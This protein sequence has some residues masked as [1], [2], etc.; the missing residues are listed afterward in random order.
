MQWA[1]S[2][3]LGT[4]HRTGCALECECAGKNR[5]CGT[6][7]AFA[8]GLLS[9]AFTRH[10]GWMVPALFLVDHEIK[11]IVTDCEKFNTKSVCCQVCLWKKIFWSQVVQILE[12][13]KHP[14]P[15][16]ETGSAWFLHGVCLHGWGTPPL[17]PAVFARV[18]LELTEA[19]RGHRIPGTGVRGGCKLL[20]RF[21]IDWVRNPVSSLQ[22]LCL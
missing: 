16:L 4:L 10:G 7:A 21:S 6:G 11:T 8:S 2:V 13:H 5:D 19:R 14:S 15:Q 18:C 20:G 12:V 1:V 9:V 17:Y 3:L 22:L